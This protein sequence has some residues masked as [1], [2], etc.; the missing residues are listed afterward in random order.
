MGDFKVKILD[1]TFR[2]GGYY[3]NWNFDKNIL[4][5]YLKLLNT[6]VSDI[7]EIGL[8]TINSNSYLGPF[9]Y[10]SIHYFDFCKDFKN[11]IFS[12]LVNWSD[13]EDSFNEFKKVFPG[14]EKD[15]IKIVRI[16]IKSLENTE[17]KNNINYLKDKGYKVCLNIQKCDQLIDLDEDIFRKKISNLNPDILYLADTNGSLNP[18]NTKI[19]LEKIKSLTNLPIG[20]HMHNNQGLAYANTLQAINSGVSYVDSTFTG[21][22]RGPGNTQTEYLSYFLKDLSI[23][24]ILDISE[25]IE[26]HFLP[27]KKK[28]LWGE[29]YF[30]FLSGL[31]NQSASLMHDLINNRSYPSKSLIKIARAD[32]KDAISSLLK[33]NNINPNYFIKKPEAAIMANGSNWLIEKKQILDYLKN[34]DLKVIHI[35]FPNDK[36]KIPYINFFASCDPVKIMADLNSYL[37][38]KDIPLVCPSN[39]IEEM[40]IDK[41]LINKVNY[42]CFISEKK[43]NIQSNKCF[44]P[45]VQS[46]CFCLS[47]MYASGYRNIIIIGAQGFELSS[48]NF[49]AIDCLN[50]LRIN[51]PDLEITSLNPNALGLPSKSIFELCNLE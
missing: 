10:S 32:E 19:L 7:V 45:H 42:D 35:N 39:L 9:A 25:L 27:L 44:I 20:V 41:E 14:T 38:M 22:G 12:T 18:S 31:N 36:S 50:K 47:Y 43:L 28:F 5:K 16:V 2:D 17:V 21:I 4:N 3:T 1:C 51:Y 6:G 46:L 29:N 33:R 30:Y 48:K 8:R 37:D 49:E 15:F 23:D 24:Q 26:G 13:V 11:I 34:N 40:K